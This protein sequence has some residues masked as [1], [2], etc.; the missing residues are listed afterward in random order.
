MRSEKQIKSASPD[1]NSMLLNGRGT[2]IF[3]Y[4]LFSLYNASIA[5]RQGQVMRFPDLAETFKTLVREGKDGFY[6]GRIAQ[7]CFND[8]Q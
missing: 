5:P 4:S 3:I 8:L 7:V 1:A 2:I 6:K